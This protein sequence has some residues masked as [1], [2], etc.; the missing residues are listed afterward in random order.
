MSVS[1]TDRPAVLVY[2]APA[3]VYCV[4]AKSLLRGKGV[5]FREIDVSRD[6]TE[7]DE[8]IQR[9]GCRTVPQI[10]IGTQFIGGFDELSDLDQQGRLDPLLG[11]DS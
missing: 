7:R 4:A 11:L 9:T 2:T 1:S 6:D 8:L 3:C 10:F 5:E